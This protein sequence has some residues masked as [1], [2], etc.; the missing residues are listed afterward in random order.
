M[1][2]ARTRIVWAHQVKGE[3]KRWGS[4]SSEFELLGFDTDEGKPRVIL[5]GPASYANPGLTPDGSRV[6]FTD[7]IEGA[8]YVVDWEG[9]NKTKLAAGFGLCAWVDPKTGRQWVY[10]SKGEFGS[11]ISRFLLDDPATRETVWDKPSGPTS[12]FQVS[13]D[14]SRAGCLSKHPSGGTI[15]FDEDRHATHGWGCETGFAPDNSYRFFHMGEW[16]EHAGVNMYDADG[17]NKR[18]V[19]FGRFPDSPG[20]DAWNPRW[21]TDVRFMTVS[22]PNA[23]PGQDVYLGVF[24]TDIT[25]IDRWIRISYGPGQDLGAHAWI[26]PGLGYWSGEAPFSI[27]V[28]GPGGGEW[29]WEFGDGN[30][31]EGSVARH[32]YEKPGR[33]T[34]MGR[35]GKLSLEGQVAVV[36]NAPPVVLDV[37]LRDE[38]TLQVWFDEPV[39]LDNAAATLKSGVKV[40]NVSAGHTK[41]DLVLHLAG[42]IRARDTLRMSGVFDRAAQRNPVPPSIPVRRP[43]WPADREDL[44]LLWGGPGHHLQQLVVMGG[45]G[46]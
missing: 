16:V 25:R 37:G 28:T 24:D 15:Y 12:G 5:P 36:S 19:H 14:G 30:T 34:L 43:R 26:D 21:S 20:Y 7:T 31:A 32:T 3:G 13:A 45:N 4:G 18:T 33:Y 6:I 10:A 46:W 27:A 23:G 39:V 44:L 1:T 29:A 35:Q 41:S 2:G 9:A 38:R 11:P 8:V 17:A 40:E 42:T 22:S